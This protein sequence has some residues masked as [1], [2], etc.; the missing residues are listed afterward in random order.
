[1]FAKR[2]SIACVAACAV[3]AL[4]LAV[5]PASAARWRGGNARGWRGG[6]GV[7]G[8]YWGGYNSYIYGPGMY[9]GASPGY[10]VTPSFYYTPSA[11]NI[12]PNNI[13]QI[14]VMVPAQDAEVLFDG[15]AT[16][17]RGTDRAF[18]SPPLTPG[19]TFHYT[20]EARWMEN[21]KQV[22]QKREVAVSAGKTATV[23]FN[24]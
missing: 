17:Q 6:N 18:V 2:L 16:R 13:A 15:D 3:V 14:Q 19:K 24:R 21:G 9:V 5:S 10:S 23:D 8:P 11:A 4:L 20:I 12:Q 1:M 7:A 22:E